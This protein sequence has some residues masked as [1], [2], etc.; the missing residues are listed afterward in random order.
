MKDYYRIL[1]VRPAADQQEIKKAYRALAFKYHPDTNPHDVYA[2]AQFKEIQE[3]YAVLSSPSKRA[4]Y[5]DE[6]WLSGMD[7]RNRTAE[8]ITPAWL[9]NVCRQLNISLAAMDTAR[10]SHG[11]LQAYILLILD[12]AHIAIL[13]KE[14]DTTTRQQIISEIL[15]ATAKLEYSYLINISERLMLLS[16]NDDNLQ[17]PIAEHMDKRLR[18]ARYDRS[19]PYIILLITLA[20]CFFMYLYGSRN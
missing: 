14:G 2:D 17:S 9:L 18:N 19:F 6:R 16:A 8:A 4:A 3:A 10:M 20:L 15:K 11:A 7:N 5:D 12:D 1:G 13:L